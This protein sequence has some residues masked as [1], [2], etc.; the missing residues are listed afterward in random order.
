MAH[1][2]KPLRVLCFG[3][4]LVEGYS[5]YGMRMTPYSKTMKRVLAAEIGYEFE[6]EVETNGVSGQQVTSGFRKRM[7]DLYSSP[8]SFQSPYDWVVFLGGTNDIA[9]QKSPTDI[10]SEIRTITNLN[11]ENGARVLILT[12]PEC[13]VKNKGLDQRRNDLNDLIKGDEREGVYVLDL[14]ALVPYHAMPAEERKEI[15]D[16][17]LHFTPEGY[18]RVGRLVAGRLIEILEGALDEDKKGVNS[19]GGKKGEEVPVEEEEEEGK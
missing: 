10:F 14:H 19:K 12:V 18:E 6:F 17:G 3:A 13:G 2:P 4:S 1:L 7:E 11:L 8:N 15:W 5:S 9:F 16:D